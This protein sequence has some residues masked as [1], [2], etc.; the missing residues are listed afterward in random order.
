M[1][2]ALRFDK[3]EERL[4][5]RRK[6]I[7]APH[8]ERQE[9]R[10]NNPS[11]SNTV[12]K[13]TSADYKPNTTGPMDID[14]ARREGKCRHCGQNWAIGHMCDRK[15]AAQTAYQE[16]SGGAQ[17]REVKT[18]ESVEAKLAQALDAIELLKKELKDTRR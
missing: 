4:R 3:L 1:A 18:D 16:R 17:R 7:F 8:N 13:T 11:A 2:S 12:S 15:R 6:G 14:Q 10:T 5:M 9:Q